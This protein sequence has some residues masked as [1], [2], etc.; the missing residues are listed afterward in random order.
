MNNMKTQEERLEYL[1]EKFKAD[2]GEYK[3]LK[4]PKD[5]DGRR[6]I[7]RSLMNIRMPKKMPEDVLKV[8]DEYLAGRQVL[9]F[10]MV[11]T[12]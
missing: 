12:L 3:N 4:T 8:Q 10:S 6:Q 5:T 2:S 9:A 11:V 1:V 7:L